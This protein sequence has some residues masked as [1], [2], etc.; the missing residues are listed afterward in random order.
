MRQ[1]G[2]RRQ[3]RDAGTFRSTR[4]TP[5]RRISRPG[6]CGSQDDE[7]SRTRFPP[8]QVDLAGGAHLTALFRSD[9]EATLVRQRTAQLTSVARRDRGAHD[10]RAAQAQAEA[11]PAREGAASEAR[12]AAPSEAFRT[13]RR[14]QRRARGAP[15]PRR[16]SRMDRQ[17]RGG[18]ARDA[19][20]PGGREQ[21]A[22]A[23]GEG[24]VR[25]CADA[26][27]Y[28]NLTVSEIEGFG[29]RPPC[30]RAAHGDAARRARSRVASSRDSGNGAKVSP[31]S[32]RIRAPSSVENGNHA[33]GSAVPCRSRG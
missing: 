2:E 5:P 13:R 20:A 24:R 31:V 4:S 25:R 7:Q 6:S 8:L 32:R 10:P 1:C 22:G 12:P 26:R 3:S 33:A 11:A 30:S 19:R 17:E 14:Q 15:A 28:L 29:P 21:P 9:H 16:G 23:G 27:G 18:G